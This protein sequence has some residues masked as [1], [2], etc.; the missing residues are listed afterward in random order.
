MLIPKRE[1]IRRR[2]INAG[3][4]RYK[5]A[6]L[7][8]LPDNALFRIE[9]GKHGYTHPLR[10]KAIASALNCNLSDIFDDSNEKK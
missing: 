7:A 4:S 5:V 10:A 3:L 2:R 9:E 1:E 6:A 8:G